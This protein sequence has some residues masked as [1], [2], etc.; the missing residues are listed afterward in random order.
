MRSFAS[1]HSFRRLRYT[2]FSVSGTRNHSSPSASTH[3]R[4]VEP[5]P[6]AKL[7]RAPYVHECESAPT[8]SSPGSTRP[9]SGSTVWQMPPCPTSKY[10]LMPIWCENSRVSRPSVALAAS[11]AGW[12]W[13][14]VTATRSGSQIFSAPICSRMIFPAG[15]MVRSCPIAKSTLART[16]S[17]GRTLSR[18][19]PRARIFSV[20]VMP[21]DPFLVLEPSRHRIADFPGRQAAAEIAGAV[22][23]ADGRFDRT[24]DRASHI[25]MTQVSHHHRCAQNRPDRVDDPP[26]GDIRRRSVHRL[27]QPASGLRVDVAGRGDSHP[28]DELGRQVGKDVAEEVARDDHLELARIAHQLHRRRVHIQM[29]RLDLFVLRSHGLPLLLP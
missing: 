5:M 28:T 29:T 2:N 13:S 15:G 11:F 7:L 17:P 10:H 19:A 18:P 3:A 25:G 27:E 16:R 26:T 12:K 24:L 8:T 21:I 1:T 23:R 4:S 9:F 14:C 20:I 6:V 22:P